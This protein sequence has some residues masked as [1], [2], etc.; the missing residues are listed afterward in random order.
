MATGRM[1]SS[2][3]PMAICPRDWVDDVGVGH[4]RRQEADGRGAGPAREPRRAPRA[5]SVPS[6][7]ARHGEHELQ[8]LA[9]ESVPRRAGAQQAGPLPVHLRIRR[10]AEAQFDAGAELI[11]ECGPD[12][13]PAGR[14]D[15]DVDPERKTLGGNR[16]DGLLHAVELLAGH[17][18]AVD[19]QERVAL[20]TFACAI[21]APRLALPHQCLYVRDDPAGEIAVQPAR[22]RA[23]VGQRSQRR[24]RPAAEVESVDLHRLGVVGLPPIP[25]P[26]LRSAVVL[27]DRGPPTMAT[28]PPADRRS[29][30]QRVPALRKRVVH[31]PDRQHQRRL[32]PRAVEQS[33]QRRRGVQRWQPHLMSR[34]APV[35]K[36]VDH[37]V[38]QRL[39]RARRDAR[40]WA[41]ARRHAP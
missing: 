19:H 1:S 12:V 31:Q 26:R 37:D 27:P 8:S 33:A 28:L 2:P 11:L 29:T 39:G 20:T 22:D 3:R 16:G 24:Q 25:R 6:A 9:G 40:A 32:R 34:L 21:A 30:D 15:D 4:P 41:D 5:T 14:G 23:D 17:R 35:G 18:P 10:V 13:G 36:A 7:Q 38:E